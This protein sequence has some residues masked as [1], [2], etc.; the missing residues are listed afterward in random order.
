M[1]FTE[2]ASPYFLI[3]LKLSQFPSLVLPIVM[4][5]NVW[6]SLSVYSCTQV[7]WH[8]CPQG[9]RGTITVLHNRH[10]SKLSTFLLCHLGHSPVRTFIKCTVIL[11]FHCSSSAF[12]CLGLYMKYHLVPKQ[13]SCPWNDLALRFISSSS[14]N[15]LKTFLGSDCTLACV[16]T[17]LKGLFVQISACLCGSWNDLTLWCYVPFLNDSCGW[18]IT[19]GVIING[20]KLK[21]CSW[22]VREPQSVPLNPWV[23]YLV[24]NILN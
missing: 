20:S 10:I 16:L 8:V 22:A 2:Q 3:S 9:W 15:T 17:I 23:I 24:I 4:K 14:A 19:G 12:S 21:L 18:S 7:W 5:G 1:Y 6:T 13:F 11:T